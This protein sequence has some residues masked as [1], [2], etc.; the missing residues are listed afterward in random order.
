[1]VFHGKKGELRQRYRE[2]MEDQ[3]G[4]LGLVVN[5]IILWNTRYTGATLDWLRELG[6]ETATVDVARLSPLKHGHINVLGRYHFE[7]AEDVAAGALRPLRDPDAISIDW[8]F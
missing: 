4:A 2:G 1:M 8:A 6:E 3:L 5:V 7:V